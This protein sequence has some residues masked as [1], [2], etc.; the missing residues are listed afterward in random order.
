MTACLALHRRALRLVDRRDKLAFGKLQQRASVLG[1]AL[2]RAAAAV[3]FMAAAAGGAQAQQGDPLGG[4]FGAIEAALT[5]AEALQ[6]TEAIAAAL[7][8]LPPQRPGIADAYVLSLS[9]WNDP[10]FENEAKEAAAI[11]GRHFDATERTLVL[12]A[13]KGQGPRAYPMATPN[14]IQAALAKIGKTIDP[15]ED[16]V[17]VFVTSHGAQDGSVAIQE[18][19]RMGGA[20][21]AQHLRA[22]LAQTGIRQKVI[23]VS[24]CFSGFFVPPFADPNTIVLTAAAADRTSFGCT[25]TRDWTYFGDALF[26]HSLRGGASLVAAYDA[27]LA[28]ISQ[29]EDKLIRDWQ[30]LSPAQRAREPEPLPSNPQKHVGEAAAEL[31]AKIEPFGSAVSCAGVLSFAQDRARAGRPLKGL[32]DVG[33]VQA[34]RTAAENRAQALAASRQRTAQDVG[35]AI[36]A[37]AAAALAAYPAQ[38]AAVTESATA[39]ASAG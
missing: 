28:L 17:V 1:K 21:R 26:S 20:L 33:V 22:S 19:N 37:G 16:L 24:A 32:T 12:S 29:W 15:L 27:S 8:S 35:K 25:P 18:H 7:N 30:A 6:Q 31:V 3:A 11:L 23:I 36:A 14:N 34:A 9:L 5:P 4:A 38:G 2:I 10:V 13:G 39:C